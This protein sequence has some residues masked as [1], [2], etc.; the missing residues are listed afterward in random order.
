MKSATNNIKNYILLVVIFVLC[1]IFFPGCKSLQMVT[2]PPAAVLFRSDD[3]IFY[4]IR[5]R[6]NAT[7]LA[8][9]FLGDANKKWIIELKNQGVPFVQGSIIVIPLKYENKGGIQ[10]DG[11]QVVPILCYHRFDK[12][13]KSKLCMPEHLFEEQIQ[14]LK[15]NDFSI[16]TSQMLLDF[17]EYREALPARS[18]MITIDDGYRS[19]YD[20]AF[21][22]LKKYGYTATIYVYT[23]FVGV[24]KSS[25]TWD[26]LKEMKSN[27]FEIG[28]HTVSHSDLTKKLEAET[29]NMYLERIDRELAISKQIIDSKLNQNTIALAYPYGRYNNIVQEI[30]RRAGYQT[31]V[32]VKFDGNPF[33]AD[34]MALNRWQILSN[35]KRDFIS[36]VNTIKKF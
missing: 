24:S 17:L 33:F 36:N 13:C 30:A 27:G 14:T 10:A 26:H 8:R 25:L 23:D 35:D 7:E 4:K 1:C 29:D 11:Y 19:T 28:S 31:A 20:I 5:D 9:K 12:N 16:I 2:S 6:E 21:P 3:Y 22:I 15:K 34:S 18:A 32:T